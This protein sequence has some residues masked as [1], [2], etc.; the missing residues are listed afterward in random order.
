[1]VKAS[2]RVP[3]VGLAFCAVKV[4]LNTPSAVGVPE[5]TPVPVLSVS[6]G[7]NPVAPKTVGLLLAVMV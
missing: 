4:T 7:G 1:M 5:I 6:P 2:A 3:A